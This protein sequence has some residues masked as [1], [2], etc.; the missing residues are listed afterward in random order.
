M[1]AAASIKKLTSLASD[2]AARL[3]TLWGPLRTI[4]SFSLA[5]DAILPAKNVSVSIEKGLVSVAYGSRVFSRIRIKGVKHFPLE[6][7]YPT[8]EG[9]SSSVV[10]ALEELGAPKGDITLSIPK[11]WAVTKIA[12]FPSSVKGSIPDVI[13]YELDRLTPF[14]QDEALY[15]FSILKEETDRLTLFVVAVKSDLILPYIEA[16]REKD[17][18]VRRVTLNVA[19][20][21]TLCYT[22]TRGSDSLCLKISE[23]DYEGAAF[24]DG[25]LSAFL[26]GA[27]ERGDEKTNADTIK[28]EMTPLI[29]GTQKHGKMPPLI[30]YRKDMISPLPEM[31]K[32]KLNTKVIL[33]DETD[34][35]FGLPI[36][37]VPYEATGSVLQSL[38]PKAKGLNLLSK[39]LHERVK[40]PIVFSIVLVAALL[41]LWAMYLVAPV[42][43]ESMKL[44][45]INRQISMRK[46]EVKKI[47]TL[48]K[49]NETVANEISVIQNFKESRPMAMDILKEI[50]SVL[51]RSPWL[52]RLRIT[53]TMV[54][55]EGY[56]GSASELLPKLEASPLLKKTEFASPT[57]RD[58]RLN[59][60]RFNIRMEIAGAKKDQG[61][62]PKSDKK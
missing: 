61:G 44:K 54:E 55:M 29:E 10:L 49:E 38:R 1:T 28:K 32:L 12:E 8:P 52:T 56:S 13:T 47:E 60:D 51:Q 25:Y 15:D 18:T 6:D 22:I 27:L 57:F 30:I 46:D 20:L 33:L 21:G 58:A 24:S 53:E 43:V 2:S 41:L 19:S 35:E 16:L 42:K 26:S 37:D 62:K 40:T 59:A 5:D 31:L 4:L 39:G 17:C 36:R 7:R 9:L 23:N 45:E 34:L 50:T 14:S 48:K 3:K 11:A